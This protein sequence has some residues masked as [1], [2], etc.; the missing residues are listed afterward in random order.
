[1][2]IV[3][4]QSCSYA[5]DTTLSI[6]ILHPP[7]TVILSVNSPPF[8][9]R[10]YYAKFDT[11]VRGKTIKLCGSRR[12]TFFSL[13]EIIDLIVVFFFDDMSGQL[14]PCRVTE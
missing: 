1:M 11:C 13:T 2:R 14:E 4:A 8:K 5:C 12:C 6:N 10:C 7:L 9:N 3:A